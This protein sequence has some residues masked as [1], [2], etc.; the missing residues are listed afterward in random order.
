[1]N[2]NILKKCIEELRKDDPKIDY[3]LGMLETLSEMQETVSVTPVIP[4][5][6]FPPLGFEKKEEPSEA[7]VMDAKARAAIEEIKR[8][9]QESKDA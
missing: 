3:V 6:K 9:S 5:V 2:T 7:D 8:M 1:M 4:T